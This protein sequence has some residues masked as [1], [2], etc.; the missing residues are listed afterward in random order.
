MA[1]CAAGALAQLVGVIDRLF[2]TRDFRAGLVIA[3]LNSIQGVGCF[4]VAYPRLL[5]V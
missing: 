4:T 1:T 2:Q 5:E 3:S